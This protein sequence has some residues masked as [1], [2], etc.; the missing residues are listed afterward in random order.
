MTASVESRDSALAGFTKECAKAGKRCA[1]R[2][3]ETDTG[4]DI[5]DRVYKTVKVVTLAS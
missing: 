2:L 3:K 1:L 4:D 5:L